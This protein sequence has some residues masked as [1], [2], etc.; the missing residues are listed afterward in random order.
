MAKRVVL[1]LVAVAVAALVVVVVVVADFVGRVFIMFSVCL[2]SFLAK[3]FWLTQEQRRYHE[4]RL[5]EALK[6]SRKQS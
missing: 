3:L 4:A 1:A 6:A 2:G 5:A